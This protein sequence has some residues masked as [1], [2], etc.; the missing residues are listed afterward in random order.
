[1]TKTAFLKVVSDVE[2]CHH[3]LRNASHCECV[4]DWRVLSNK[5]G[6]MSKN[7]ANTIV[8]V[9]ELMTIQLEAAL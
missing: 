5:D 6:T 7:V 2:F 4:A 9:K 3:V 8:N 1:M